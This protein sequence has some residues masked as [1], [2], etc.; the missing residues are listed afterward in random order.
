[1]SSNILYVSG[2]YNNEN[3]LADL[4]SNIGIGRTAEDEVQ[5]IWYILCT[6]KR[7]TYRK[8]IYTMFNAIVQNSSLA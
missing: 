5:C 1:M 6:T 8:R 3:L 4:H 2:D 7:T